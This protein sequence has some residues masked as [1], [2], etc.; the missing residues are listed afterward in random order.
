MEAPERNV[1]PLEL[2]LEQEFSLRSFA[3][4]VDALGEAQSKALLVKM[5]EDMQLRE[6]AY[7]ARI[8]KAW[9]IG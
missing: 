4:K 5:Y 8:K 3:T 9:G 7:N 2:S 1:K 6:N